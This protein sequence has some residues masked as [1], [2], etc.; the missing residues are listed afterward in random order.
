MFENVAGR[1]DDGRTPDAGVIGKLI[2]H[3]GA[4]GSGELIRPCLYFMPVTR[5]YTSGRMAADWR[6]TISSSVCPTGVVHGLLHVEVT[7]D[8]D[9]GSISFM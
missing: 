9:L 7:P 3:L 6:C 2:A 5:Y 8:I 4:F 1:T